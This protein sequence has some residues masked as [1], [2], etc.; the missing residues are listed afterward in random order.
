M[1]VKKIFFHQYIPAIFYDWPRGHGLWHHPRQSS[2]TANFAQ[3]VSVLY[4]LVIPKHNSRPLF[5]RVFPVPMLYHARVDTPTQC[6]LM[7]LVT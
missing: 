3:R 2:A 1:K 5:S 7:M 4:L 6:S